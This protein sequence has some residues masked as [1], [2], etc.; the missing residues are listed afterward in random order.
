MRLKAIVIL[1]AI[2]ALV[3]W[4]GWQ[5]RSP[6]TPA[7]SLLLDQ[8]LGEAPE[9]FKMVLGPEPVSFPSDHAA[10]PDYRSEWWY[11]TGNLDGP[12]G[13]RFGFQFTLFRFGLET[14][15]E[16][17][18][19]W[20]ADATWMAH[21]A[22]SDGERQRF[23]QRERFAR[24][25]LGLAGATTERWWL[26]DWSVEA[27]EQGWHLLAHAED[28]GLELEMALTRPIVLQG[29]AGFSRKGPER[30]NASRYYSATR[31]ATRGEVVVDQTRLPVEGLAWLDREW[32]S[33]QLPEAIAGW[34]WFA[35][36]LDDGR[37]LMLYRL[38][39]SDGQASPFSAGVLVGPDGSNR[40]LAIEDFAA[41]PRRWW[42]GPGGHRWPLQWSV[43]VPSA[44]LELNVEPVFDRQLW[45]GSVRYWEGAMNVLDATT[46]TALGRGY[47]ELSGYSEGRMTRQ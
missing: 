47:L 27:T 33:G 37:D 25:A 46:G 2:V 42:Q 10:H 13:R 18:S 16:R 19:A 38:R 22:L 5:T 11:F 32:G 21:L 8:V 6:T 4:L 26:R 43:S 28:F 3:A 7:E 39:Q 40:K 14:G 41:V 30:G 9:Q 36:H 35:L 34:D 12:D 15:P 17:D 24:G 45:E 31:L 23:Y 1:A 29:E 20:Q 44:G